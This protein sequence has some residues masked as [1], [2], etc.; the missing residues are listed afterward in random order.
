MSKQQSLMNIAKR[1]TRI[2]LS[3]LATIVGIEHTLIVIMYDSNNPEFA[4]APKR[5]IIVLL[6]AFLFA[7]LI[8]PPKKFI[9]QIKNDD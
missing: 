8:W 6:I 3:V 2:I 1:L 9:N 5:S 4:S 7:Y